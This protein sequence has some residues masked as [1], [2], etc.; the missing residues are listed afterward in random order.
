[1]KKPGPVFEALK[2][3]KTVEN[4]SLVSVTVNTSL[5]QLNSLLLRNKTLQD[6]SLSYCNISNE[7]LSN[8]CR[9]FTTGK[10][11]L[12]TF[13]FRDKSDI[14][15]NSLLPLLDKKSPLEGLGLQIDGKLQMLTS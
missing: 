12:K 9:I 2:C 10:V 8:I 5:K 6:L 4:L 1:M 11:S 7:M 15:C 3:N 13:L 14:D